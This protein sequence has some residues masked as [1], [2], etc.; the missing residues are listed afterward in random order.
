MR[1]ILIA[2]LI[3]L[4]AF[5]QYDDL[6]S[7]T[8]SAW[9]LPGM[10][11]AVVQNDKVVYLKAFGVRDIATN[12]PM[13]P[14]T[15]FEIAS[16]TKAFTST[17]MAM[18]VD[19]KKMSFD[20][21]VRKHIEYFHLADPC[22]DSLVTLRDIVSHRTG[23]SR[24]D[25][26]W[27]YNPEASR[28][29]II[30][31]IAGVKLSRQ[32]RSAYQYQNI[33]FSTAGEAVA[34]AAKMPWQDFMRTRVFEPLGMTHTRVSIADFLAAEHS[35]SYR[36]DT[37]EQRAI[38][39]TFTDYD[40]IAPA[41]TIKSSAR[42]MAQWLRFQLANGVIDGRRLVSEDTLRETKSPQTI[43]RMDPSARETSPE[44]NILTYG[45]GW[46]VADYRGDLLVSHGGA[47]NGFRTQVALLP[48]KNAGIVILT[49]IGRG[50][51]IIALRNA[52]LDRLLGGPTRDWNQYLM[53]VDKRADEKAEKTRADRIA[54]R[55]PNTTPSHALD[56]YAG[57]YENPS[58]GNVV[59]RVE[60]GALV[61]KWNRLEAQ[62]AHVHYDTFNAFSVEEEIDEDIQFQLAA[63]GSVKSLTLFDEEFTK[64]KSDS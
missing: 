33:M 59:V 2:L 64:K 39:R 57:T 54:K 17:A 18:L 14:D 1:R 30:R 43:I 42:D 37:K 34:S 11:V 4:P 29:Q 6:A 13:T 5:A 26:L 45:M 63:D 41:G 61:M 22:A 46:N 35:A 28:E 58:Y 44:T 50:F 53:D 3:A 31:S 19:D 55:V 56:A 52:I 47:L 7:K 10:A 49:N 8:M 15:L 60:N 32:F 38:V 16:T 40:N 62:L 48:K 24:H 20:D 9:K 51:G 21:P 23:L 12:A 27:D 25:E 36:W